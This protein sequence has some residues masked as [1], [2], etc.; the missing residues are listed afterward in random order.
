MRIQISQTNVLGLWWCVILAIALADAGSQ[1]IVFGQQPQLPRTLPAQPP[2][3]SQGIV[4]SPEW[5]ATRQAYQEW[6]TVQQVYSPQE[7]QKMVSDLR[8][9]VAGMNEQ[10]RRA[11]LGDMQA[12]LAVLNS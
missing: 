2:S 5:E 4:D 6:L 8:L 7:V 9:R 1:K 11:F 3:S 12:R 10:Q